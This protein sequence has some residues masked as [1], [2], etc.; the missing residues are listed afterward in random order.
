MKRRTS[1][2]WRSSHSAD[3]IAER[4]MAREYE[5]VHLCTLQHGGPGFAYSALVLNARPTCVP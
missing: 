3:V 4:R 5:G 1:V 2:T